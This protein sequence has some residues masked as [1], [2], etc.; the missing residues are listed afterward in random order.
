MHNRLSSNH[1]AT[2]EVVRT[3]YEQW[4]GWGKAVR[5]LHRI[6]GINLGFC[7]EHGLYCDSH[8]YSST[9][10]PLLNHLFCPGFST[11]FMWHFTPVIG[12]LLPVTHRPYNNNEIL[13]INKLFLIGEVA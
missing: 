3:N 7:T 5:K 12:G 10:F 6:L 11:A 2:F 4:T 13:N 1:L 8:V 9:A